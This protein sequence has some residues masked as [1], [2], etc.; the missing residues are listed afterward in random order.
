MEIVS[1]KI[2]KSEIRYGIL[3]IRST[4]GTKLLFENLPERFSIDLRGHVIPNRK[5]IANKIW[6][7]LKQMEK[8]QPNEV[9]SILRKENIIYME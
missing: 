9:V 5:I 7:G 3:N 8:F 4:D 6:L 1:H 2:V